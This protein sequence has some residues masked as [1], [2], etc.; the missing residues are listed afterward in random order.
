MK[1]HPQFSP[2]DINIQ[3]IKEKGWNQS[4]RIRFHTE[5]KIERNDSL[6]PLIEHMRPHLLIRRYNREEDSLI[7]ISIAIDGEIIILSNDKE[8]AQNYLP[9]LFLNCPPSYH[10]LEDLD[11]IEEGWVIDG[12]VHAMFLGLLMGAIGWDP[13]LQIPPASHQSL[14]EASKALSIANYRSCVVMCRRTIEALLKFAF[15]R[16]LKIPPTDERGRT[17]SLYMMIER[18]REQQPLII[19]LYLLH[20]LDSIRLIGNIPG[21]HAVEIEGYPF[22]KSDAEYALATVHYFLDQYFSKID[23]EVTKYY[24]LRIELDEEHDEESDLDNNIT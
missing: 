15:P 12:M 24:T 9:S 5:I 21:A 7:T 19:P 16:L 13:S 20:V 10:T 4:D 17:L 3:F 2:L 6:A 23:T 11:F 18:F 14:E 1:I 8:F 22:T